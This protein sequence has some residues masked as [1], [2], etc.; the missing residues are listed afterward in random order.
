M[1]RNAKVLLSLLTEKQEFQ[2]L[3]AEDAR[4]AAARAGLALEIHGA[5]NDPAAQLQRITQAVNAPLASRPAAVIAQPAAAAGL[6]GIGRTAVQAGIGWVLLGD[7]A[8]LLAPLQREF[9]GR[10]VAAVGTDNDEIGRLQARLFRALL[11][12]G[13]TMVYVEGPSFGAAAIHRRKMMLDGL[14]G[15]GIDTVKVLS[16]DWTASSAERAATFWLKLAARIERPDLVG[17]QNDEMAVGVRNAL[18]TFRP[19]WKGI[20]FTGV[21]GLP[22]GGQ[23]L[24][25][26]RVLVATIVTPSPTGPSVELVARALRGE[27]VAPLT[28]MPPRVLPP[29]EELQPVKS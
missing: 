16:G 1:P 10:L 14:V 21:D 18:A 8:A 25:R 17:S 7:R 13:G 6:E 24:V 3:Q 12:G 20:A 29:L 27:K 9:P 15:S 2:R 22:D 11:P 19:E 23:R 4:A 26:E 28:L 5:E